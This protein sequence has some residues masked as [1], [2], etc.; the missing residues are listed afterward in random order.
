MESV[1]KKTISTITLPIFLFGMTACAMTGNSSIDNDGDSRHVS[2]VAW[3]NQV[4]TDINSILSNKVASDKTRLV[5][6]RG[7]DSYS[8]QT[9]ANI[10]VNNRFQVS[11]HEGNYTAVESCVGI[12][13]LSTHATGFKDNNLLANTEDYT[14]VGG[15]TYFFHV[16]MNEKGQSALEQITANSASQLLSKKRYQ[17]HQ[18]SRVVPN[19]PLPVVAPVVNLPI[20]TET[21]STPVAEKMTIDL[22]ILF[23]TD[24]AVV[25][26]E[27]YSKATE[28][29]EFMRQ[30][31]NTVVTIEG[32]TDS[33]G[34]DNYNQD[35]SQRRVNA[36]K[37]VLITEFGI[38]SDRIS[39]IGYGESQPRASNDTVDGRQL[40]RRVVAVVEE[41][42]RN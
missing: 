6:I 24:K 16:N 18:I 5:F 27:Y 33:R 8:E 28:L 26:P 31:P 23:E 35:L 7:N 3:N 32:H 40:N 22:E 15:Q 21:S 17:S 29:V 42:V 11:L 14:L 30:Y 34:K 2:K 38:A 4:D 41:R 12:N 19:C 25:R 36:V 10:S 37:E 1:L 20:V 13:K 9:S 39:A